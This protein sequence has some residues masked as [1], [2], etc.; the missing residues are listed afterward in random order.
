VKYKRESRDGK[1]L[2]SPIGKAKKTEKT[3]VVAQI[4]IVR[5]KRRYAQGSI[6]K[7]AD[8]QSEG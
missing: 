3:P 7:K 6:E 2:Q 4:A 8:E 1:Q 5:T